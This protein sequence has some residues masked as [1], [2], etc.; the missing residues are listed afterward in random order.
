MSSPWREKWRE[1]RILIG[2]VRTTQIFAVGGFLAAYFRSYKNEIWFLRDGIW[3]LFN[4]NGQLIFDHNFTI[5]DD[6]NKKLLIISNNN[7]YG[8]IDRLG[9]LILQ[10]TNEKI[11]RASYNY[12][13]VERNDSTF[14]YNSQLELL[15]TYFKVKDLVYSYSNKAFISKKSNKYGLLSVEG[16]TILNYE[17]SKLGLI[18]NSQ[19]LYF[20]RN[21][22]QGVISKQGKILVKPKY[23]EILKCFG[24]YYFVRK[25][26]IFLHVH[27]NGTEFK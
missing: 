4:T 18:P 17:Y 20:S 23:D 14:L 15:Q 2:K 22:K 9:K 12:I 13:V 19:N 5:D 8:I 6:L 7:G 1:K 11:Y 3:K 16:G 24:D 10:P 25:G 21:K 26:K 27:E